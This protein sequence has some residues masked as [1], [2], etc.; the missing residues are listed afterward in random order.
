MRHETVSK[1]ERAINA[2]LKRIDS[3]Y[4]VRNLARALDGRYVFELKVAIDPRHFFEIRE[5]L[6]SIVSELPTEKA[7]QAKFYLPQS[8]YARVKEKAAAVG[9]SQSAYVAK[10]LSQ[11]L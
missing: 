8:L 6:K 9:V 1:L 4:G 10:C 2:K 3:S 11:N 5:I 7:V